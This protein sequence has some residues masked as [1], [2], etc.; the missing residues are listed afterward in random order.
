MALMAMPGPRNLA[1]VVA[2]P[3]S[4]DSRVAAAQAAEVRPRSRVAELQAALDEALAAKRYGEDT[5]RIQREL[6][7]ARIALT[8]AE[9][10]TR[11]LREGI[12][13]AE[14]QRAAERKVIDDAQRHDEA[15]RVIGDAIAGEKRA[16][17]GIEECIAEM[18]ASL[19]AARAA[20]QRAREWEG[21][22]RAEQ[23]RALDAR[24]SIGHIPPG[25]RAAGANRASVLVDSDPL[26]REL[27]RWRG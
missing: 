22:V 12:A 24:A 20:W 21:K 9:A 18:R 4:T 17:D 7:E 19:D 6:H 15:Q 27:A 13:F 26:V 2:A 25:Q 11:G 1:R 10:T 8:E 14:Q 23:Q 5:E 16:R 3:P